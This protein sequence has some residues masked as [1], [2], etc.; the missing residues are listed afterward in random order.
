MKILNKEVI[1]NFSSCPLLLDLVHVISF[2]YFFFWRKILNFIKRY[3]RDKD[4]K[5]YKKIQYHKGGN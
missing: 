4:M 1:D 2:I 5:S 3:Y